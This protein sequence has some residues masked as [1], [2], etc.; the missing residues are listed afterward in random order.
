VRLERHRRTALAIALLQ[1]RLRTSIVHQLTDIP[2]SVLR[3]LHH[4]IHGRKPASGQLPST[5]AILRRPTQQ[6]N[7]SVF[8]CLYRTF[9][10]DGILAAVDVDALLRAHDLYL[11]QST[12]YR[13]S[14]QGEQPIDLTQAWVIARDLS[15]GVARL[16]SCRR[17]GLRHLIAD[18]QRAPPTCP[19]CTLNTAALQ[20]GTRRQAVV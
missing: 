14:G 15:T 16:R 5:G 13:G 1:R 3:E 17:C 10:G 19:A 11:K 4:E 18:L 7:A 2:L 9:G 20:T 12:C 8:A 6:M